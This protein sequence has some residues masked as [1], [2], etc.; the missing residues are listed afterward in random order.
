MSSS[1]TVALVTIL[2]VAAGA[3]LA[4]AAVDRAYVHRAMR[5]VGDTTFHPISSALR[6]PSDADRQR[7]RAE[8]SS[9]LSLTA[10]QSHVVDSIL[11]QRA[12]QFESLRSAIRPRVDSL[13]TAVRHDIDAVLTPAQREKYRALQGPASSQ[14]R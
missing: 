6:T 11:D 9:A 1:R 13:V 5:F 3:A 4:G 7:Y 10:E 12:S 14:S 2:L 8:L